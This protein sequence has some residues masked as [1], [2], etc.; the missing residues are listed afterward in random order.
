MNLKKLGVLEFLNSLKEKKFSVVESTQEFINLVKKDQRN[1]F[2]TKTTDEALQK[3]KEIDVKIEKEGVKKLSGVCVGVK[4]V[5]CTKG[6]RT[7]C[8]SK[9]LENF[10]PPYEA[11]VT[12]KLWQNDAIMIGKTNMD[13]LSMGSSGQT[14]YFGPAINVYKDKT[15]PE[16]D[17][18]P[19]G[20][21]SGSA[22]AVAGDYCHFALGGDT[23]GSMKQP[24]SFCNL[25]GLKPTYGSCSR[26]GMIPYSDSLDQ[27]GILGKNVEDV[28]YIF[29]IISGKDGKDFTMYDGEKFCF[30]K[31]FENFDLRG[32]KIGRPINISRDGMINSISKMWDDVMLFL[33]KRGAIIKDVVIEHI[34]L[35]VEVYYTITTADAFSNLAKYDGIKFG[36]SAKDFNSLDE[37][38]TKTRGEGFGEE[39]KRRIMLGAYTLSADHFESTFMQ[40]AKIKRMIY[41]SYVNTF[42]DVDLIITPTTPNVAFG[43]NDVKTPIEMYLNDVLT[44]PSNLAGLG[45]LSVPA[46]FDDVTGL[47]M[48]IQ[49]IPRWFDEKLAFNIGKIIQSEFKKD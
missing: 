33:E 17:L 4:D 47:P 29:D 35:G 36:Y 2:I 24:A 46:G 5:F 11:T 22:A 28:A 13:E 27:A 16:V 45:G 7:T 34:D 25:V 26:Y 9:M 30:E 39:V 23:G 48:G 40:A 49:L 12:E 18:V 3:A 14:S 32:I 44:I 37:F 10:I 43:M 31:C 41:D 1:A 38:Y 20:S 21:S 19:G 15:R 42:N 8:G 6:V